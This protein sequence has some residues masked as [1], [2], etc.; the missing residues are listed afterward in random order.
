MLIGIMSDT[1]DNLPLVRKAIELFNQRKVEYVIHAGD[2]T[3]PF[4]LKLFK[5]LRCK[6]V[7]IFGNNDGD[8]VL[9]LDRAEGNIRNQPYVFTLDDKKI[10]VMHEHQVADAL[11]DS[12]HFDLVVYGH[13][14]KPDIRKKKNT[15]LVNPGEVSTYLYGKSTVALVDLDKMEA[16]I[17]ELQT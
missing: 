1:H 9:L 7:G 15:L 11:A 3:S 5:D 17:V 6:Y 10:V 12:G 13:T 4:T 2:Y 16:E 14:H 8:K